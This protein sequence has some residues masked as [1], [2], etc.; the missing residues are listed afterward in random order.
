[1][2]GILFKPDMIQA[3]IEGRKTQTR[4]VIK[5]QPPFWAERGVQ[6]QFG[7]WDFGGHTATQHKI[8]CGYEPRYHIGET[9]YI[10]EAWAEWLGTSEHLNKGV[11]SEQEAQEGIIY[12]SDRTD[13]NDLLNNNG[14]PW[15]IKSTLFMPEWAA[16]YFIVIEQVRAERVQEI[17]EE[18]AVKEGLLPAIKEWAGDSAKYRYADLWDSINPKY[19]WG[20]NPWVFPYTFSLKE[21]K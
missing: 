13:W 19:P 18:D 12:K 16:R 2:K 4:R 15:E 14:N 17:T 8:S 1:M 6:N 7:R 3:I 9:V 10:K 20:S 21:G 5:P 11:I